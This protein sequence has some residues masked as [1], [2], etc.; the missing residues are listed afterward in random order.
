[1][2]RLKDYNQ[3]LI[4]GNDNFSTLIDEVDA[5]TIYIGTAAVG[6]ATGA[7]LW[8][9]QKILVSGTVTSVLWADGDDAF[10]QVWNDRTTLN[11]S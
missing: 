4:E 1:M 6:T 5:N 11:Y 8:Q 10:N 7:A 3:I 9:I 2:S